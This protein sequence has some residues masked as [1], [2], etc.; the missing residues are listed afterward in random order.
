M[1]KTAMMLRALVLMTVTAWAQPQ[2]TI[3]VVVKEGQD[4]R[5]LAREYLNDPDMWREILKANNLDSPSAIKP[6]MSLKIPATDVSR[7]T[8]ELGRSADAIEKATL[9][10][11]QLFAADTIARAIDLRNQALAK[12]RGGLWADCLQLA[13]SARREADLASSRSQAKR[14]VAGE[15]V[16]SERKGTVQTRGQAELTWT[17]AL[18]NAKLKEGQKVRTLADSLAEVRFQDGSRLRLNENSQAVIQ[19]MRSDLYEK[20]QEQSVS[21]IEGDASALLDPGG[22]QRN[23]FAFQAGGAQTQVRSTKFWIKKEAAATRFANYEGEL[24]VSSGGKSVVLKAN[25]GATLRADSSLSAPKDLLPG[26]G[27]TL[28]LNEA[29]TP[30]KV[31]LAWDAIKDARS[32]WLEVATDSAFKK[33]IRNRKDLRVPNASEEGLAE[34]VYFWR[35]AAIDAEAFPGPKSEERAFRVFKDATPPY[36]M[37]DAPK[38]NTRIRTR[39]IAI[40]G[41]VEKDATLLVGGKPLSAGPDGKF[42]SEVSLSEGLNT[43]ALVATDAAGNVSTVNRSVVVV[44]EASIEIVYDKALVQTGPRRFVVPDRAFN[45]AGRTE[46]E[47]E[48]SLSDGQGR[49]RAKTFADREGDFRVAVTLDKDNED[50]V[51]MASLPDARPI[52]E[53]LTVEI[54]REPPQLELVVEPQ[55]VTTATEVRFEGTIK[56]ASR[57]MVDGVETPLSG[58]SF[59][60][61]IRLKP[62]PNRVRL[63]AVDNVGNTSTLLRRVILDQQPPRLVKF[64]V[65]PRLAAGGERVQ[66]RVTAEDESA[67]REA[68]RFTLQVGSFVH[69]GFLKLLRSEQVYEGTVSLP[70]TAKGEIRLKAV[71]LHDYHGNFKEYQPK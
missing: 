43:I 26:P 53:K 30:A 24:E 61:R 25:Q 23:K 62:G 35:V 41:E 11:S 46:A 45:L 10:G 56:G 58:E 36:L 70:D 57:L 31:T 5:A 48:I 68:A 40:S 28:P 51:L 2:Q 55:A 1:N 47:A 37:L 71:T 49:V 29:T 14:H 18:I 8:I 16:L 63:V 65:S 17:H 38:A 34:G 52:E 22:R 6:G 7:A 42:R 44:P 59:A 12:R 60:V 4:I 27:L 15:A 69:T 19:K 66:I 3:T 32:Y 21:L 54:D 50:L 64:S 13:A 20:K 67:L 33:I 9:A 39:T